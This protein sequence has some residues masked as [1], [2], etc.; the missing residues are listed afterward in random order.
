MA[1][2]QSVH[3]DLLRSIDS[4]DFTG[5]YQDLGTPL[6]YPTAI[7][8][9]TNNC[10]N[11]VTVSTDGINDMDFVPAGGFVL[12]DL[13]ANSPGTGSSSS[14]FPSNTQFLVK[15]AASTGLVYLT[16]LYTRQV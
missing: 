7:V 3:Y 6:T 13:T 16:S 12:Y 5:D 14:S 2:S 11:D 4:A 1:Y 9:I 10:A 15:G 8:K